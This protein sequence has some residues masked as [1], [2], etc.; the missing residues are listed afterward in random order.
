MWDGQQRSQT[1]EVPGGGGI[2]TPRESQGVVQ[3]LACSWCPRTLLPQAVPALRGLKDG[4]GF[5]GNSCSED[6]GKHVMEKQRKVPSELAEGYL[7]RACLG[8]ITVTDSE[9]AITFS[10]EYGSLV[11]TAEFYV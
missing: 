10:A 11:T 7:T 2:N 4:R 1:A 8:D 9:W 5:R 3:L 6:G